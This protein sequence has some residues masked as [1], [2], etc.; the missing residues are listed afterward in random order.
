M[1][2]DL[3]INFPRHQILNPEQGQ[4]DQGKANS[5]KSHVKRHRARLSRRKARRQVGN[6]DQSQAENKGSVYAAPAN[7]GT[8]SGYYELN[9]AVMA[10]PVRQNKKRGFA[11]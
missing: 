6:R 10:K 8:Q 9:H 11:R 5:G 4:Q 1:Q 2:D 7:T 3:A